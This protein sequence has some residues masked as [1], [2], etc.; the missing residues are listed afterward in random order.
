MSQRK[1]CEKQME[2]VGLV[3]LQ[4]EKGCGEL[5]VHDLTHDFRVQ[6]GRIEEKAAYDCGGGLRNSCC[7]RCVRVD[8]GQAVYRGYALRRGEANRCILEMLF[9]AVGYR[10]IP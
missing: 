10:C 6:E 2:R 5:Q 3:E 1:G 9:Y 8:A 4:D 7:I